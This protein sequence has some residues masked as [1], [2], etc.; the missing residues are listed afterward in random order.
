M[1]EYWVY[2]NRQAEKGYKARIHQANCRTCNNG[3]GVHHKV[4]PR[5]HDEWLGPFSTREEALTKAINTKAKNLYSC[6]ICNPWQ[7]SDMPKVLKK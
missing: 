5:T 4:T 6:Q 3:Q 2:Y 1:K 7:P